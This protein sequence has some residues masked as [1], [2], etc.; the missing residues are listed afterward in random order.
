MPDTPPEL[1]HRHEVTAGSNSGEGW[2]VCAASYRCRAGVGS[3][4]WCTGGGAS[5]S[6][7][8][9]G[10]GVYTWSAP[11]PQQGLRPW[12]NRLHSSD[13]Y[14][15][16]GVS[17]GAGCTSILEH[18]SWLGTLQMRPQQPAANLSTGLHGVTPAAGIS[19]YLPEQVFTHAREEVHGI[20][21]LLPGVTVLQMV[22]PSGAGT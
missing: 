5:V 10:V 21:M 15:Q 13:S 9:E 8:G 7:A 6:D 4:S 14:G 1:R 16:S 11:R 2:L 18:A 12:G 3:T 17:H 20:A 22:V 19:E